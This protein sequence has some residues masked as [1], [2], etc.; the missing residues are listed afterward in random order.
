M[1]G[2]RGGRHDDAWKERATRARALRTT[3]TGCGR[4]GLALIEVGNPAKAKRGLQLVPAKC[5]CGGTG[6]SL[7]LIARQLGTGI[8]TVGTYLRDP[9]RAESRARKVLAKGTCDDCGGPTSNR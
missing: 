8:S 6:M 5:E 4:K 1:S 2:L 3:C 9:D 7:K